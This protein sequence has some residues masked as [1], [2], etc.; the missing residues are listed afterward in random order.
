MLSV[1]RM[2]ILIAG[3]IGGAYCIHCVAGP[4]LPLWIQAWRA[5]YPSGYGFCR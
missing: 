2:L 1:V 5:P 4:T 3:L